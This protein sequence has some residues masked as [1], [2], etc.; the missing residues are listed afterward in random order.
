MTLSDPAKHLESIEPRHHDVEQ[1][2]V[3]GG[4]FE[5]TEAAGTV[6]GVDRVHSVFREVTGEKL[7]QP[8]IVVDD[9][10]AHVNLPSLSLLERP[11]LFIT[12]IGRIRAEIRDVAF[13]RFTPVRKPVVERR[14][15]AADGAYREQCDEETTCHGSFS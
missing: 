4:S 7:E 1:Y 3:V 11:G 6:C 13:E 10:D 15:E 14:P 8:S 12:S 9:E 2:G 5:L